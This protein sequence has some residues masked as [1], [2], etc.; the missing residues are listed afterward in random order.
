MFSVIIPLY[1]KAQSITATLNSVLAQTFQ[2]FEIVVINDGSTDNSLAIVKQFNDS[3]IR[4]IDQENGGVSSA[5]NRG[6]RESTF[7]WIAFLD[8]DDSWYSN[9]LEF[10]NK[11]IKLNADVKWGFAAYDIYKDN[12]RRKRVRYVTNE[13][14]FN[15]VFDD[16]LKGLKI[17]TSAVVVNKSF[18]N[19]YNITFPSGINNS[20][21]REVW[22]KL[23]CCNKKPFYIKEFLSKYIVHSQQGSLTTANLN[24]TKFHFIDMEERLK[25]H[26]GYASESDK[27]KLHLFIVKINKIAIYNLWSRL[28]KLP[29][30]FRQYLPKTSYIMLRSTISSPS[31]LKKIFFHIFIKG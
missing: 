8:A 23:C 2:D 26:L 30:E 15:N 20:E 10:F 31:I 21:D 4:I 12:Y 5:R 16:L 3:R 14:I 25:S 18:L 28:H 19:E 22:Y 24:E 1:N 6:V 11:I 7:E 29:V 17:Q 13:T 27:I 9:K